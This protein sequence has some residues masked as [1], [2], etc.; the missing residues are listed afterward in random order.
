MTVA[1]AVVATLDVSSVEPSSITKISCQSATFF[2]EATTFPTALPSLQAGI[3][4]EVD[5]GSARLF[6]PSGLSFSYVTI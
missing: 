3:I 4:T 5:D 1:P 2:N 6:F